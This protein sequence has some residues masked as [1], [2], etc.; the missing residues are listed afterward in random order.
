MPTIA[1]GIAG[2][3]LAIGIDRAISGHGS[4]GV[5]AFLVLFGAARGR[6]AGFRWTHLASRAHPPA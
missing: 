5:V 6:S 4:V 2:V 3:A 1:Y